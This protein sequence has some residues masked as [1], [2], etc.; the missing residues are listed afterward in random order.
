LRCLPL[1]F[2]KLYYHFHYIF[3]SCLNFSHKTCVPKS[4]LTRVFRD[5]PSGNRGS[6]V[7]LSL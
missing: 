1:I 4:L 6:L 5:H 3:M 2:N 7:G